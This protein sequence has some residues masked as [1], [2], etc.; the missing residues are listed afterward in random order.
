[1][2]KLPFVVESMSD[3]FEGESYGLVWRLAGPRQLRLLYVGNLESESAY[4]KQ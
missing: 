1:M 2:A 3:V 4:P